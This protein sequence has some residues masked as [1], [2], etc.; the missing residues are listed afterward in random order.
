MEAQQ[1]IQTAKPF[2]ATGAGFNKMDET[3]TPLLLHCTDRAAHT[4]S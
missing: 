2:L 3:G 1:R 4:S